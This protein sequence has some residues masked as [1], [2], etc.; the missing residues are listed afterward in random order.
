M[1]KIFAFVAVAVCLAAAAWHF[2]YLG[3][4]S[5]KAAQ[6]Q[7]GGSRRAAGPINV[8]TRP[9]EQVD[10][11]IHQRSYGWVEPEQTVA[12]RARVASQLTEQHFKEGDM[13]KKG[14]LLF[15]LDDRELK[16]EVDKDQATLDKDMA[17]QT[18]AEADLTRNKQLVARNAGT[19]QALDLAIADAKSAAATVIADQATLDADK[20]RLSY[21]KIYAPITGRTGSVSVTPGNL[22]SSSDTT[23]LVVLTSMDPIRVT[24]SLPER[25]LAQLRGAMSDSNNVPVRVLDGEQVAAT[26]KLVFIDSS[27]DTSTGTITAKGLFDNSD[28]KLWP[29]RY[30]DVEVD[31]SMHPNALVAPA[32][33]LQ[34]GQKGPYVFVAMQD[35]TAD[36]REVK[37]GVSDGDRI[38]I[39][40]GLA[41]GDAVIVE[42]Q[43]RLTKGAKIVVKPADQGQKVSEARTT[44]GASVPA[45]DK[46]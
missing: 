11:P 34:Q 31:T 5:Q 35:G 23:P 27:V 3:A 26:G 46:D 8:V 41:K 36:L 44:P 2:G 15:A 25:A 40:S 18:R 4:A 38:E 16:A 22:V 37:T 13:M 28:F 7:T 39:L 12:I 20:T 21:T 45:T 6:S 17:L 30:V 33:A 19:Q 14:D 29:G 9:V 32:V 24:F 10:L 1:R 42:G 43:Q